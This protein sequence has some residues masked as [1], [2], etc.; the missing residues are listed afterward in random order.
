[1][2]AGLL[3]VVVLAVAVGGACGGGESR[4]LGAFCSRVKVMQGQNGAFDITNNTNTQA[5]LDHSISQMQTISGVAPEAIRPDVETVVNSLEAIRSSDTDAMK[6]N[7]EGFAQATGNLGAY[8]NA[9]CGIT[10]ATTTTT[11]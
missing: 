9:R 11:K 8:I 10:S 7:Q 2:R 6:R 5:A 4:S 3:V 1:M